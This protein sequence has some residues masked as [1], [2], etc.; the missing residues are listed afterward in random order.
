M[1]LRIVGDTENR[2]IHNSAGYQRGG[3]I[4]DIFSRSPLWA[5]STLLA[6][7]LVPLAGCSKR[8]VPV[9]PIERS[10]GYVMTQEVQS[11]VMSLGSDKEFDQTVLQSS[12]PVLVDFWAPWCGPCRAQTPIIEQLAKHQGERIRFVKVNVDEIESLARRFDIRGIPTLILFDGGREK[13]RLVGLQ[14]ME[15]LKRALTL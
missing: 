10:E 5:H 2:P 13:S 7:M 3:R 12:V 4:R 9:G 14:T 15:D 8:P 11:N 6:L 1:K